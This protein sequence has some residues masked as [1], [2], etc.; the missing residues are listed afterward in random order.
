MRQKSQ[1]DAEWLVGHAAAAVYFAR[2]ILRCRLC[3]TGDDAEPAGIRHCSCQFGIADAM[4]AA[5]NDRMLY[6][7]EFGNACF[8]RSPFFPGSYYRSA[9][10]KSVPRCQATCK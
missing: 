8:Y 7:E 3:Q 2:Q 6:S 10:A 9:A 4:H 5:L 1:I